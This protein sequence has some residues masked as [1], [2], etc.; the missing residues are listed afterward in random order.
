MNL[1]LKINK[2]KW[3]LNI[4]I[5]FIILIIW[6]FIS[7]CILSNSILLPSPIDVMK[8]LK[9]MFFTG[10]IFYHL[11]ISIFR[12]LTGFFISV[13]LGIFLG[14][15]M[16]LYKTIYNILNPILR[17]LCPIPP[18]AWLP[19]A[20]LWFGID[21]GSK[22]FIIIIASFFPIFTNVIHGVWQID[23]KYLEVVHLYKVSTYKFLRQLL[24]PSIFPYIVSGCRIGLGY[25]W[26]GILAAELTSGLL[27]IGYLLVDARALGETDK[28]IALM[29]IIGIIGKCMDNLIVI[30]TSK[31][32]HL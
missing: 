28:V 7:V 18:I 13:I 2:N 31:I 1:L 20:I 10:E 15:L 30:I 32:Y 11:S 12:V 23:D 14:I 19:L 21:E 3:I 4:F 22:I 16:G 8:S 26:M 17:F 6:Q 9:N 27:G 24:L 29:I 5:F 25:A